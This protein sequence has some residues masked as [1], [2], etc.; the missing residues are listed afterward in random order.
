MRCEPQIPFPSPHFLSEGKSFQLHPQ[1][2]S[3]CTSC[4][5]VLGDPGRPHWPPASVLVPSWSGPTTPA[6]AILFQ[7]KSHTILLKLSHGFQLPQSNSQRSQ[8]LQGHTNPPPFLSDLTPTPALII[9]CDP[10][11][12]PHSLGT[13]PLT[14]D[15]CPGFCLLVRHSY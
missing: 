2:P 6:T 15:L 12:C 9:H 11:T 13:L 7:R 1:T 3:P 10:A 5:G 8:R 4:A 14:G